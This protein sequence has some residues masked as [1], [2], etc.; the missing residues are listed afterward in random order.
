MSDDLSKE[1]GL[2][3]KEDQGEHHALALLAGDGSVW[4]AVYL[5]WWMVLRWL[6]WTLVIPRDRKGWAFLNNRKGAKVRCRVVRVAK[7]QVSVRGI[8]SEES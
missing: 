3:A 6:T 2:L 7:E 5:R 1:A 4:V 8:P